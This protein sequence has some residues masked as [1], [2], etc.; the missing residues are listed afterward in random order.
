MMKNVLV[1]LLLAACVIPRPAE[2]AASIRTIP[3]SPRPIKLDILQGGSA[4]VALRIL[5]YPDDRQIQ[6]ARARHSPREAATTWSFTA[7]N[8]DNRDYRAFI[9]VEILAKDGRRVLRTCDT[10]QTLEAGRSSEE[11]RI[12]CRVKITDLADAPGARL[13]VEMI[14]K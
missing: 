13:T 7:Q 3:V 4:L 5:D 12:P 1:G 9:R 11:I 8:R 6:E 2:A 14:P 10:R